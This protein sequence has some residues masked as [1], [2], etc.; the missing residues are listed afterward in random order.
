MKGLKSTKTVSS[1]KYDRKISSTN[2]GCKTYLIQ[3]SGSMKESAAVQE[4]RSM[5]TRNWQLNGVRSKN[6]QK[7]IKCKKVSK[8]RLRIDYTIYKEGSCEKD[9][10]FD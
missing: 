9:R 6:S 1:C 7:Q 10:L 8:K 5:K 4:E 3:L 2:T